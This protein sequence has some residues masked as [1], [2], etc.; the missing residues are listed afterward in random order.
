MSLVG[1]GQGL[2]SLVNWQ[3]KNRYLSMT[4]TP[5]SEPHKNILTEVGEAAVLWL[6]H[7]V[8]LLPHFH[9]LLPQGIPL[10]VYGC[11]EVFTSPFSLDPWVTEIHRPCRWCSSFG[12]FR[13]RGRMVPNE[14]MTNHSE[15]LYKQNQIP[16]GIISREN[17]TH[18]L[19]L[20]LSEGTAHEYCTTVGCSP[21]FCKW[22]WQTNRA[23]Q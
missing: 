16:S 21:T 3:L 5:L 17:N 11:R 22:R 9:V 4:V 14:W 10:Q 13:S 1:L 6:A 8:H 23:S 19:S 12:A 15:R 18:S 2:K 7:L 20:S